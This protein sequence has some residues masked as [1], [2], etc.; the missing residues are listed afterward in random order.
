MFVEIAAT[1]E[2]NRQ[3]SSGG[4]ATLKQSDLAYTKTDLPDQGTRNR[5]FWG[6]FERPVRKSA[7]NLLADERTERS[8]ENAD[9]L[10]SKPNGIYQFELLKNEMIELKKRVQRSTDESVNDQSNSWCNCCDIFDRT[11]WQ[12]LQLLGSDSVTAMELLRRSASKSFLYF[13]FKRGTFKRRGDSPLTLLSTSL[14]PASK[15]KRLI[16]VLQRLVLYCTVVW[17]CI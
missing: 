9:S 12:G 17:S 4:S 2:R 1:V 14:T 7:P 5:G 8:R 10:D 3:K 15:T 16:Q 6:F 11:L 13:P